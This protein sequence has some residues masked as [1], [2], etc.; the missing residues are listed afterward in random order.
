MG[1]FAPTSSCLQASLPIVGAQTLSV[2]HDAATLHQERQ[3][4]THEHAERLSTKV[5]VVDEN[6]QFQMMRVARTTCPD[7]PRAPLAQSESTTDLK[8]RRLAMKGKYQQHG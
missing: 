8:M 4:I 5:Q 6:I 7:R 3:R 2:T 1:I